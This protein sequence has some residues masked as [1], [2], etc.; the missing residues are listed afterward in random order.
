MKNKQNKI[1]FQSHFRQELSSVLDNGELDEIFFRLLEAQG[2]SKMDWV[3]SENVSIDEKIWHAYINDLKLDKPVQYIL[4]YEWFCGE[5]FKVDSNVLIPRP[6]TEELVNWV[7][8]DAKLSTDIKILEIGTGSGCIPITI[9]RQLPQA[10]V[11]ASDISKGALSV[12]Q[13]NTQNL[14]T[15]VSFIEDDILATNIKETAFDIIISNPPYIPMEEAMA[16]SERVKSFEP[17]IAL[18]TEEKMP[19]Q[20]YKAILDFGIK[21]LKPS[22]SIYF[23]IHEDYSEL[24]QALVH[25]YNYSAEV[26]K[27][28]YG[29][30]R[31]MKVLKTN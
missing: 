22:G 1:T 8:E 20:F 16:I 7:V 9:K 27:D 13:T 31:M 19:L 24:L 3:V 12:A 25:T 10:Q 17:N 11:F 4:G 29:K 14:N 15:E 30:A 6:E 5:K 2:I 18:F 23:E 21:H 26:K 28:I